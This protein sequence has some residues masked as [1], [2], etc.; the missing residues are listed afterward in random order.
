MYYDH[1]H[2]APTQNAPCEYVTVSRLL[3]REELGYDPPASVY[4]RTTRQCG[5]SWDSALHPPNQYRHWCAV[6]EAGRDCIHEEALT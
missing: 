6:L 3:T 1:E 4:P 2:E 5:A